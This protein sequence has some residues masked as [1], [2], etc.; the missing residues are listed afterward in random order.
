[1]N[2]ILVIEDEQPILEN[3][4][5]TLELEGFQTGGAANGIVGIHMARTYSPDLI[6]CDIMMP[7]MDGYGVLLELRNEPTTATIP[8]IFLTA[9]AD[10]AA[11]RQG[12][13]LGADDYLTKPFTPTELIASV[14]AR[15]E[16]QQIIAIEYAKKLETLRSNMIHT[17]PHELRTPLLGILSCADFLVEDHLSLDPERVT[18]LLK[19]IQR[20]GQRLQRL[21]ENYLL[22][23][24]IE[25]IFASPERIQAMRS[26]TTPIAAAIIHETAHRKAVQ[27]ERENDLIVEVAEVP[28]IVEEDNLSKIMEELVDNAFKFSVAGTPVRVAATATDQHYQISVTNS[29]RGLSPEQTKNIGAYIQFERALYEQQGLGLGLILAKRLVELHG[30]E[31]TIESIPGETMTVWVSL[32]L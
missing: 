4:L 15:L 30:G 6:L 26:F 11:M 13:E 32:P 16:K 9:R 7:E 22:Y 5:E 19:I 3:I 21:I 8:F 2:R 29:G 10:R 1:M 18:S 25:L 14:R 27:A 12:M 20:S 17:L 24:Q 23:A 28:V 31:L